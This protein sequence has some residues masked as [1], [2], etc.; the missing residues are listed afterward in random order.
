MRIETIARNRQSVLHPDVAG[1]TPPTLATA[2]KAPSQRR[3]RAPFVRLQH[4]A[5]MTGVDA[6]LSRDAGTLHLQLRLL[7][8]A[9]EAGRE[10][11]P[12]PRRLCPCPKFA[13]PKAAKIAATGCRR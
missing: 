10:P 6:R 9:G 4:A 3:G 7:A 12:G 5:R 1:L 11:C 13:Q 8:R 2:G